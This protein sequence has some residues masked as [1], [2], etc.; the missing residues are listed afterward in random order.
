MFYFSKFNGF[1]FFLDSTMFLITSNGVTNNP[2]SFSVHQN[3]HIPPVT[4]GSIDPHQSLSEFIDCAIIYYYAVAHKY[5]VMV[6]DIYLMI[7]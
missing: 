7:I 4:F 3:Q 6:C 1:V 5:V 2:R